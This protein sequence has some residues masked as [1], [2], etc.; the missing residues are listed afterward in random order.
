M[1]KS[2]YA[3]GFLYS[4]KTHQILLLQSKQKDNTVPLWSM[5]GGESKE[6]EDAED[7]FQRIVHKLLKVNLKMKH[8]YPVY[9]YF[10]D[11]QDKINYVF[12]AEVKSPQKFIPRKESAFSWVS[13]SE[14]AKLRFSAHTK[15]DVIVGERVINLKRRL[16]QH[17][18]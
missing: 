13:F 4:L 2:F 10:H 5:L 18:Q 3:S 12:Y 6:G 9:D 15:Q 16:A 14:I 7:T 11:T 8:I 1:H 17:L